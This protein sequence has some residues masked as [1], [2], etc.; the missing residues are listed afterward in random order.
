MHMYQI[1][2]KATGNCMSNTQYLRDTLIANNIDT[3]VIVVYVVG[4]KK[5]IPII[6]ENHLVVKVNGKIIDPSFDVYGI[7]NKHYF[8]S[9]DDLCKYCKNHPIYLDIFNEN[10]KYLLTS[11]IKMVKVATKINNGELCI[12]N[13]EYYHAQDNYVKR[14]LN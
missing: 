3:K 9:F 6:S 8:E 1:E 7:K 5:D 13:L 2:N 14:V 12:N 10:K 11:N 4:E